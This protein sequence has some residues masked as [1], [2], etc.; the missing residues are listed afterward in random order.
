MHANLLNV[1]NHLEITFGHWNV[2]LSIY[3]NALFQ[4]DVFHIFLNVSFDLTYLTIVPHLD[5]I[6]LAIGRF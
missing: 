1:L 2:G 4:L 6:A 3:L 5:A